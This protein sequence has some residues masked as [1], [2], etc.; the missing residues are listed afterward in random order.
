M[1][2]LEFNLLV[3]SRQAKTNSTLVEKGVEY[4][5]DGDRLHNFKTS[6]RFDNE[7]PERALWGMWKKHITSIRDEVTKMERDRNYVPS[8]RWVD[9]K[10]GD[11]INY[12]HL[13]EGLIEERRNR[14]IG[15]RQRV[16]TSR[17]RLTCRTMK[18]RRR[19]YE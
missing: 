12:T 2:V 8:R 6:G 10:L 19:M 4:A 14:I 9:E 13:L 3:R 11:N 17:R 1:N 5:M 18:R 16:R 7:S 15:D